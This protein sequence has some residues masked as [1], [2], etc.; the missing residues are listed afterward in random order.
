MNNFAQILAALGPPAG[1]PWDIGD[2]PPLTVAYN[3]G[4][5]VLVAALNPGVHITIYQSTWN[6][7]A[8]IQNCTGGLTKV[9]PCCLHTTAGDERWFRQYE[10]SAWTWVTDCGTPTAR[11]LR[12]FETMMATLGPY[13][14]LTGHS[15]G[16]VQGAQV[17]RIA[18]GVITTPNP[19]LWVDLN[20]LGQNPTDYQIS[21]QS[22]GS[23]F[24]AVNQFCS[25]LSVQWLSGGR[26]TSSPYGIQNFT[27]PQ[28]IAMAET[29]IGFTSMADQVGYAVAQLGGVEQTLAQVTTGMEGGGYKPGK[30]IWAGNDFHVIGLYVLNNLQYELYD[31]NT[32]LVTVMPR[33]GF[34]AAMLQLGCDAFVVA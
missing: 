26:G 21:T 22:P 33:A 23:H 2:D 10:G 34:R 8:S 7:I 5:H 15:G 11:Y 30:R 1:G 27:D 32:G 19:T 12:T 4:T 13:L 3:P 16:H 24:M 18:V 29:L 6:D 9:G 28:K 20:T 17:N 25:I 14:G 31:S